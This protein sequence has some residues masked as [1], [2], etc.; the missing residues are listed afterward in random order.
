MSNFNL[1]A[2]TS[3][4]TNFITELKNRDNTIS[5]LFSDGTTHTGA[6]PVRAVRW[7]NAGYFQRRNS[8]NNNLE[9]L[10]GIRGTH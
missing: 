4:Y 2:L 3:T 5:S 9:R 10:E 8:A 6:Y 1:P 7:N